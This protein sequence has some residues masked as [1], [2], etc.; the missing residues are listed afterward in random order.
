M[1]D[2]NIHSYRHT[3]SIK[4]HISLSKMERIGTIIDERDSDG[5]YS[6]PLSL[7]LLGIMGEFLDETNYVKRLK[8]FYQKLAS[9]TPPATRPAAQNQ[10]NGNPYTEEEDAIL[11]AGGK[12]EGRSDASIYSRR[13]V[14][15]K[16]KR[17]W[18]LKE[19]AKRRA[20]RKGNVN[21]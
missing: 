10:R 12:P 5:S 16:I 14:L 2:Y 15:T 9:N 8:P 7:E 21:K 1:G 6:P 19:Y 13:C 17:A 18:R 11:L 20:E 3:N 4:S